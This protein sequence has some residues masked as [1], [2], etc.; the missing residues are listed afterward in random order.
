MRIHTI[1]AF[2]DRPFSGNPAAVVLPE[3]TLPDAYMQDMAAELRL[4]E[5]AFLEPRDQPGTWGL[6]WFTPGMEVDLC[7]HATLGAAHVLLE[8]LGPELAPTGEDE[9]YHFMTRSGRLRAWAKGSQIAMDLPAA[10]VLP[11][12]LPEGV[13]TALG[14]QPRFAGKAGSYYLL[15]LRD[16]AAVTGCAPDFR[17][18]AE[19]GTYGFIITAPSDD[20]TF[21]FVSRFFAPGMAVPEDP[22]TGSAHCALGTYWGDKLKLTRMRAYQASPR[23]GVLELE[24]E[25][26]RMLLYGQA[27]TVWSGQW[28]PEAPTGES[29]T[30]A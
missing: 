10:D 20:S 12:E 25:G 16:A 28:R 8:E 1:N 30:K 4:S 27:R 19:A 21:S 22:V 5:T 14:V 26:E 29:N 2:T 7:G 23:G 24:W 11:S 17:A 15:E 13:E 6:R 3:R 9:A 18:L